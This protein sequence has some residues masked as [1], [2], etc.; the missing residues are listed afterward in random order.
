MLSY[1]I[2]SLYADGGGEFHLLEA[3]YSTSVLDLSTVCHILKF[4]FRN[5]NHFLKEIYT[6][7]IILFDLS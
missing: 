1:K 4:S 3:S 2:C 6:F 7:K 5:V